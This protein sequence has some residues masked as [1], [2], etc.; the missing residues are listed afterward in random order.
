MQFLN[1]SFISDM[2]NVVQIKKR[3]KSKSKEKMTDVKE[4]E[5]GGKEEERGTEKVSKIYIVKHNFI[6]LVYILSE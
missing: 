5:R 2:E 1:D 3:L 4:E 6:D